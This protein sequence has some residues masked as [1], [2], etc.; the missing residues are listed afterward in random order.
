VRSAGDHRKRVSRVGQLDVAEREAE[1]AKWPA[2]QLQKMVLRS[3]LTNA[4]V[5][6]VSCTDPYHAGLQCKCQGSCLN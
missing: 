3:R 4:A 2:Q 6:P 1:G 5:A